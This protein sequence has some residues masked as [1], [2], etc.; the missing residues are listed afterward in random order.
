MGYNSAKMK[1]KK[2]LRLMLIAA[3]A[4]MVCLSSCK[5]DSSTKD[6]DTSS[7]GNNSNSSEGENNSNSILGIWEITYFEDIEG[8]EMNDAI[9]ETWEFKKNGK[10][11]GKLDAGDEYYQCNWSMNAN[12]LKLS[13]GDLEDS[14]GIPYESFDGYKYESTYEL[15]IKNLTQ[16]NLVVSGKYMYYGTE[17]YN[18]E[19]TEE[20]EY[21]WGNIKVKLKRSD[22]D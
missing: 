5:K 3:F 16:N 14:E 4:V 9:G 21:F 10:F 18:Y 15:E 20:P 12:I 2:T 6:D 7:T 22:N 1:M 13:G 19:P 17:W 8:C 11:R